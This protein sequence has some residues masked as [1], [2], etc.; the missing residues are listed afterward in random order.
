MFN[1]TNLEISDLHVAVDARCVL[2]P[3]TE[4]VNLLIKLNYARYCQGEENDGT[5][6]L[7]YGE[8]EGVE[9]LATILGTVFTAAEKDCLND[10]QDQH[11]SKPYK[12]NRI[13]SLRH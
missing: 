5:D 4:Y 1:L 8:S 9:P 13:N 2:S 7:H 11:E 6:R 12:C 10:L 3:S